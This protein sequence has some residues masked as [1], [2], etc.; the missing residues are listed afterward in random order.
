NTEITRIS[1]STNFNGINLLDGS[2][3][4]NSAKATVTN[5]DATLGKGLGANGTAL[6]KGTGLSASVV[7]SWSGITT[8]TAGTFTFETGAYDT[9]G[10]FTASAGATADTVR[11][12]IEG[13]DGNITTLEA[14][15]SD[16]Y[17]NTTGTDS[18]GAAVASGA[19]MAA[20]HTANINLA[21]FGLGS[22]NI[23]ATGAETKANILGALN[24][25][26]VKTT[27]GATA[28]TGTGG[29]TLQVGDTND[30]FN[31]VTVAVDDLSATGLGTNNLSVGDREAAGKSIQTIKDAINKVSTNRANLGALQNRLDYAINNLDT[32]AENMS[33]AN[34]RIRDT[35]MAKEMM[36]YTKMNILTQAAQGMLAQ[37]NQQPQAILQLLQ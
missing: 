18:T 11:V 30:T 10:K 7:T 33:S 29:L 25:A 17:T 22:V 4:A 21:S 15:W 36:T 12:K 26:A 8:S 27:A 14:K 2:L 37:A 28:G 6:T 3:S 24:S 9:A 13:T 34:S 1:K 23:V 16:V 20:N 19:D 5:M 31:K 35:D 32:T